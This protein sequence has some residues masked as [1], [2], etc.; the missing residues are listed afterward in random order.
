MLLTG[1]KHTKEKNIYSVPKKNSEIGFHQVLQLILPKSPINR[2]VGQK[3]SKL[4]CENNKPQN[5]AF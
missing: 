2:H 1:E 4:T 5:I 3:L